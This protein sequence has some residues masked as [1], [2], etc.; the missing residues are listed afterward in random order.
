MRWLLLVLFTVLLTAPAARAQEDTVS[1]SIGRFVEFVDADTVQASITVTCSSRAEVIEAFAYVVQRDHNSD[2][3]F[4]N[5]I[6]DGS[7]H[8]FLV[9]IQAAEGET[10]RRGRARVSAFVLL[11]SGVSTSPG[12][13]VVIR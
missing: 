10:F 1:G 4:F 6:C 5:P 8:T 9:S 3:V 7:P 2:F 11:L 13:Q 12:R